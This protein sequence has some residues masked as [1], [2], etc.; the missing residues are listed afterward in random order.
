[1]HHLARDDSRKQRKLFRT[2]PSTATNCSH[3]ATGGG[4][5]REV[6]HW[7]WQIFHN[8]PVTP[9][10]PADLVDSSRNE[11]GLASTWSLGYINAAAEYV[12]RPAAGPF[13]WKLRNTISAET[14]WFRLSRGR[15]GWD[16]MY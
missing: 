16:P 6:Y 14:Q 12:C 1:M 10:S 7:A 9:R 11:M 2:L 4:M 15:P 13:P 3:T 5:N 8:K